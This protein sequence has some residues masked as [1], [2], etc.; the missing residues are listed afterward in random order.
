MAN[1]L[2]YDQITVIMWQGIKTTIGRGKVIG[3]SVLLARI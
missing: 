3:T 1:S 2:K